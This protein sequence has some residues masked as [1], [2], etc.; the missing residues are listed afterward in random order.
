MKFAALGVAL[1]LISACA[2]RGPVV[3]PSLPESET[4]RS[5]ELTETPFFPQT[6]YYCGP[7]SLA[8]LLNDAG[9]DVDVQELGD[10]V[11]LPEKRGSLQ[12]EMVAATRHNRRLPYVID[13]E[14]PSLLEEIRAG[15][16]VLVFQNLGIK[17]LPV[18]HYAV[19]IGYDP[20]DDEIVLRSGTERRKVMSAAAFMD[21]WERAGKWAMVALE[22]GA[23]P[24]EPDP[25]RYVSAVA[26]MASIDPRLPLSWLRA[27]EERWPERAMVPFAIGNAHYAS[28]RPREAARNFRRALSLDPAMHA[29]RNNLAHVL[30]ERG[31]ADQAL[32][33]INR[34]LGDAPEDREELRKTLIQ[35][36]SEIMEQQARGDGAGA[37]CS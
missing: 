15:R 3:A 8:M 30:A 31:C 24:V 26:A 10:Q 12:I 33:E 1:A 32:E 25:E 19:V 22:P 11:Y 2:A 5:V 20:V 9:R 4:T 6:R 17:V 23:M 14:L 36:R 18:W 34:A 27:A 13:G 16:P 29:A 35:T 21:T 7:A 37:S 28:G